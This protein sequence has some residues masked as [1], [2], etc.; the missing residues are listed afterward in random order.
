MRWKVLLFFFSF[1]LLQNSLFAQT[2]TELTQSRVLILLDESSSMLQPWAG[3]N[4]KISAAK[5]LIIQLMDSIW[6]I[7]GEVEF[8]LRVFGARYSAQEHNCEDTRN[9]VP[10]SKYNRT[11][12]ELRLDDLRPTGVTA[13]AYSLMQAAMYDLV[14]EK[15]NAYSI[16][17]ITDGGESCGGDICAVMQ[18]LLQ[19][20]VYFKPYILSLEDVPELEKEYACLG[21][22]LKITKKKEMDV[23]VGTIV[24]A[25]KP[26]LKLTNEE[27][28]KI[29]TIT[30][31]VPS[32]LK[33]K[34]SG[35][36]IIKKDTT[37]PIVKPIKPVKPIEVVDT[38]KVVKTTPKVSSIVVGEE[39][40]KAMAKAIVMSKLGLLSY[41]RLT[42]SSPKFA[43]VSTLAVP[44]LTL[45]LDEEDIIQPARK[46]LVMQSI[47]ATQSAPSPVDL[48]SLKKVK[49]MSVAPPTLQINED[50]IIKPARQPYTVASIA[51]ASLSAMKINYVPSKLKTMAVA[52]PKFKLSDDD[53]V[54]ELPKKVMS[55]IYPTTIGQTPIKMD[56]LTK[57]KPMAVKPPQLRLS[58]DDVER[59]RAAPI[60]LAEIVPAITRKIPAI[61]VPRSHIKPMQVAPPTLKIEIEETPPTPKL[62]MS[63]VR[64]PRYKRMPREFMLE[65]RIMEPMKVPPMPAFKPPVV[66]DIT[67]VK[68]KP[69]TVP[70]TGEYSVMN[71]PAK[72]TSLQVYLTNGKGKFYY[73]TPQVV[74][75]EIGTGKLIKKFYRT[76]DMGN[77]PDMITDVAPGKYELTIV[78]RE[79]LLAVIDVLAGKACKVYV[80]VKD[81]SLIFYYYGDMNRPVKEFE[82]KVTQ[83][84]VPNGKVVTQKCIERLEYEPGNYH[85]EINTL[86]RDV[87]NL[88][89]DAEGAGS[90]GIPQPGFANFINDVNATEVTLWY[91]RGDRFIGFYNLK[92]NDPLAKHFMLQPGKYQVH[93]S[94]GTSKFSTSD[95]V[96]EFTI[97]SLANTDVSLTEL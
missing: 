83:R 79:D 84:N 34:T 66:A 64:M 42:T 76:I 25:F 54:Y 94:N 70:K 22:Y 63:T 39:E 67:A 17:L 53:K 31:N 55:P 35:V 10:F 90:I 65:E 52:A 95:R 43:K 86:P 12:M 33:V 58:E 26:M 44:K 89:L 77:N 13:I 38:P 41:K 14:D 18:Q 4:Q 81:F 19:K 72:E 69:T 49:K 28:T 15:Y 60:T 23:A 30:A 3:G 45:K 9:E 16:V 59:P 32:V 40:P 37:K 57:L 74:I 50:D 20:K 36:E 1:L 97:K 21:N 78:G 92:M 85:I 6:T 62:T 91:Q 7:N 93:Y 8:S 80:K 48:S 88:D 75:S 2:G 61:I 71:E 73:T 68:P 51:I 96:K 11:Q 46:Q 87:R 82:A 24:N 27:Y 47:T 5:H 56:A 29:Q